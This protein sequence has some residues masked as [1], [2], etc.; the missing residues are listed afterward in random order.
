MLG[1][2]IAELENKAK[3]YGDIPE[4]GKEKL[5]GDVVV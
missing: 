4:R 1:E 3:W 5:V 2:S